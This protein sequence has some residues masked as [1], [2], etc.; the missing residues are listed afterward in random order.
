MTV[1]NFEE[2]HGCCGCLQSS[3]AAANATLSPGSVK[4]YLELLLAG[5]WPEEEVG[6]LGVRIVIPA[7]H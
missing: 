5:P 6:F 4:V 2:L 7:Q 1:Q 3:H